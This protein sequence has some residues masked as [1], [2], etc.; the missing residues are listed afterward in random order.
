SQV[1]HVG[2]VGAGQVMK[3]VNNLVVILNRHTLH[4]A[5]GLAEEHGLQHTVALDAMRR[6]SAASWAADHY[7][8]FFEVA[9]RQAD[10]GERLAQ[11]ARK[12]LDLAMGLAAA[13]GRSLP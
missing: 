12:D 6:G 2:E 3:I 9:A 10:R 11:L 13:V 8:D 4:Q 5:L 7:D 1:I